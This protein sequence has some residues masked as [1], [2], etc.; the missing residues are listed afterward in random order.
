MVKRRYGNSLYFFYSLVLILIGLIGCTITFNSIYPKITNNMLSIILVLLFTV[1]YLVNIAE[2]MIL[3]FVGGIKSIEYNYKTSR[4]EYTSSSENNTISVD[5]HIELQNHSKEKINFHMK[6]ESPDC[7]D[8]KNMIIVPDENNKS[9]LFTI[10]SKENKNLNF[11]FKMN[12]TKDYNG[13][14]VINGPNVIIFNEKEKKIFSK[15]RE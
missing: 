2:D 15:S 9:K 3:S 8:N 1:P 7:L 13:G 14:G 10:D 5:Y 4:C 11:S 6:V 12:N